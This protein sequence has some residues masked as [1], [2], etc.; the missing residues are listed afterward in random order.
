MLL[1]QHD[2][3]MTAGFKVTDNELVEHAWLDNFLDA[4]TTTIANGTRPSR[5]TSTTDDYTSLLHSVESQHHHHHH[6]R[7]H[8]QQQPQPQQPQRVKSEHSYSLDDDTGVGFSIKIE[9]QEDGAYS[10]SKHHS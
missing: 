2:D 6:H 8:D 7:H 9:P 4:Q 10:S 5:T 1:L 3:Y